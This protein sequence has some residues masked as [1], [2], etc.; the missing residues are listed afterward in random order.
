MATTGA[1]S[2]AFEAFTVAFSTAI[3][4]GVFETFGFEL[5]LSINIFVPTPSAAP[6]SASTTLLVVELV[7]FGFATVC[8]ATVD[9]EVVIDFGVVVDVSDG[10]VAGVVVGV[11]V[12]VEGVTEV[13]GAVGAV[14]P[15]VIEPAPPPVTLGL[16][17]TP[18]M[19]LLSGARLS[20]FA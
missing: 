8:F 7:C 16:L 1:A 10:F 4:E 5:N 13:F 18:L 15:D 9:G 3:C 17:P 20:A 14:E 2:F 12:D 6:V 19:T 11:V